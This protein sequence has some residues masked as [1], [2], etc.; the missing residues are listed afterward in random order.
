MD[1]YISLSVWPEIGGRV[2]G[3]FGGGAWCGRGGLVGGVAQGVIFNGEERGE[4]RRCRCAWVVVNEV[5]LLDRLSEVRGSDVIMS[6][7]LG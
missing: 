7:E 3:C 1:D 5:C 6:C 4:G 2:S